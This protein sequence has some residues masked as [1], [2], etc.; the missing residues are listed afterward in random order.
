MSFTRVK[1]RQEQFLWLVIEGVSATKAYGE[2]YGNANER[3][4]AASASKLLAVP[5]MVKRRNELIAAKVARQP[6]SAAFLSQ[7][8]LATAAESRAL[9]QGSAA[10]AAY[11]LVAKLHGL[12]VDR[13]ITDVLVRKP[14]SIPDSPD[15]MTADEWMGTYLIEGEKAEPQT[16]ADEAGIVEQGSHSTESPEVEG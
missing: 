9:G 6:V 10:V 1:P 5:N 13:A 15:T 7:E 8:A 4:C 2:V 14:S 11:A 3:S 12:I 16:T